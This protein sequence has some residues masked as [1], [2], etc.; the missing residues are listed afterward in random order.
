ME[1]IIVSMWVA[2]ATTF[3]L[4]QKKEKILKLKQK[5]KWKLWHKWYFL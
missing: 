4:K 3:L 1:I 2:F 5:Q